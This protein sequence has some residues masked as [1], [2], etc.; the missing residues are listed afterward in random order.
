MQ[1]NAPKQIV[2]LISVILAAVS[3]VARFI[4]IPIVSAYGWWILLAGFVVLLLGVV[5]KG[6]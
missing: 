5:L 1:L 6:F 3:V 2:F 4:A